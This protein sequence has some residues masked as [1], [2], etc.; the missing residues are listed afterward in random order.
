MKHRS[1]SYGRG[2]AHGHVQGFG[3]VEGACELAFAPDAV[4]F[5][6]MFVGAIGLP[7]IL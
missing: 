1:G 3:G 7:F 5:A 6:T 4:G 2:G